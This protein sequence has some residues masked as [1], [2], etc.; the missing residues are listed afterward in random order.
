MKFLR[1]QSV[2]DERAVCCSLTS[3]SQ[4]FWPSRCSGAH[5]RPV[6]RTPGGLCGTTWA[7]SGERSRRT[8]LRFCTEPLQWAAVFEILAVHRRT[9]AA[10]PA[11]SG[12]ISLIGERQSDGRT[13]TPRHKKFPWNSHIPVEP[14]RRSEMLGDKR[15]KRAAD[16]C[17]A[18]RFNSRD[19]DENVKKMFCKTVRLAVHA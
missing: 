2:I 10:F 7:C 16:C 19:A 14:I 15:D 11:S 1:F 12:L 6:A 8:A 4:D 17:G 3:P 13:I 18:E 9:F 5:L